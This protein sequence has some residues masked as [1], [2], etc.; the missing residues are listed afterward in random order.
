MKVLNLLFNQKNDHTEI[1]LSEESDGQFVKIP[2]NQ[3]YFPSYLP[4]GFTVLSSNKVGRT[5]VIDIANEDG[6]KIS[7]EQYADSNV[8]FLINT[9]EKSAEKVMLSSGI[10]YC[11]QDEDSVTLLWNQDEY[12]FILLTTLDKKDAVKIANSMKW[13][14]TK[15]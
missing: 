6:Q 1:T 15:R 11:T 2:S 4:E 14:V 7:F 12:S 3:Y 13:I 5:L 10:G 8:S 9:E